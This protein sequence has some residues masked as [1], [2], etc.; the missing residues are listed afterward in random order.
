MS[1]KAGYA[2]K[3]TLRTTVDEADARVREAL[4]AEGFGILTEI[5]VKGTLKKKIGVD[6][7]RYVILGAC[8]PNLAH[9]A[10]QNELEIGLLLPCNVV[11]REDADGSQ[12]VAFMDPA[13]VLGLV[14]RPELEEEEE[15][16]FRSDTVEEAF[17]KEVKHCKS[18]FN[19]GSAFRS[20]SPTST[21][22]NVRTF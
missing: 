6:F 18:C 5:D 20:Q 11:V 13:S 14:Q 1:L 17:F 12:T 3:K 10:L 22:T 2:M 9:Q 8:N 21:G 16:A 4:K 15:T 19:P 7:R